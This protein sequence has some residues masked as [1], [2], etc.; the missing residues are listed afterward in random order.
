MGTS[1]RILSV[2]KC[3][4]AGAVYLILTLGSQQS[5]AD[6]FEGCSDPAFAA[7][8]KDM[9]TDGL[10]LPKQ[11]APWGNN[12]EIKKKTAATVAANK[13]KLKCRKQ[14]PSNAAKFKKCIAKN[15]DP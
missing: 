2:S 15:V 6:P 1:T 7:S 13:A 4:L 14:N 10:G 8:H 12:G 9:C 5:W 11:P 3:I